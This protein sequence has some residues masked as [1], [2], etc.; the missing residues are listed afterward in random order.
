M[1]GEWSWLT[2][3][4]VISY[5]LLWG[6]VLFLGF[7]LL[8]TLR[9]LGLLRWRLEQLEATT[10]S[11]LGRSGLRPGKKA[12][13]FTLPS[14]AGGDIALH[15]FAGRKVLLV[16]TQAGCS[17]CHAILPELDRLS[18]GDAQVV[19]VHKGDM[20]STQAWAAK[21]R[22]RFPVLV[23]DGLDLSRKYEA[24]A[25]PFAFLIDEK[26]KIAAKGIITSKEHIGYVLSGT[27][28]GPAD[29]HAEKV[30]SDEPQHD[31]ITTKEVQHV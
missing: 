4:W 12:P 27:R 15:D 26:G 10:P 19:V 16:F 23:Q 5:V 17:P 21:L 6:I 13:D 3:L 29:G 7:L 31:A 20:K 11:R 25:T 1:F 30:E 9:A 14:V 8:G 22:V 2:A 18:A 24:F 28:S